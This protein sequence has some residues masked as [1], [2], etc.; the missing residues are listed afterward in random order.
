MFDFEVQHIPVRKY[1]GTD[2]LSWR[3]LTAADI[4]A[5]ETETD[6][7]DFI[8]AELISFRVSSIFLD[9]STP[10]LADKYSD[11]SWKIA[12]YLRTMRRPPEMTTK[13]FNLFKMNA[14]K[15]KV[16]DNHL[17]CQNS[18]N[19]PMRRLVDDPVE[20]QTIL[21]QLHD[22]NGYKRREGTYQQVADQYWWDDFLV[23]FKSYIQSCEECQRRDLSRPQEALPPSGYLFCGKK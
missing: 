5:A 18:K 15:F 21:Q 3:P 20:R 10:I 1:T 13:E 6:T 19:V 8:L 14:I 2:E 7:D 4:K 17:F 22:E 23:E 11:N 9:E 16:Q 12:T